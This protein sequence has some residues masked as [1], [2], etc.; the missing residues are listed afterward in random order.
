[1][2]VFLL[3]AATASQAADLP[4]TFAPFVAETP[5]SRSLYMTRWIDADQNCRDTRAEVLIAESVVAVTMD[6]RG[7]K[8]VRGRWLDPYTGRTFDDPGKLQI[9]HLVP[10]GEVH[11]SGG[12]SWSAERRRAYAQ[13]LDDPDTLIAVWGSAN[14]SKRDRDPAEWMPPN[15]EFHCEYV[16]RWVKVKERWSLAIDEREAEQVRTVRERCRRAEESLSSSIW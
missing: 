11:R 4:D 15:A 3:V 7:C 12:A 9:D 5:Y 6:E 16:R 14:A 1:V 2:A 8:V 13:D 10:L